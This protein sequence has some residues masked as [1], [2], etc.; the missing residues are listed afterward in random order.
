MIELTML[1]AKDGDSILLSYGAGSSPARKHRI[2]ID[3]G[4]AS[5]YP[6]FVPLLGQEPIDVLVIT[7][8]DQDHVLGVLA[9]FDDPAHPPL[10]D[11]WFNGFD[12]LV[13]DGLEHFGPRD[14]EL[15]TAALAAQ[16][17]AWNAAFGGR[18]VLAGR[19]T[20]LADGAAVS[21]LSPE[22]AQLDRLRPFWE[23][24]CAK[25]GLIPGLKPTAPQLPGFESLGA[26]AGIEELAAS[27]FVPDGS[28]TNASS[29][30]FLF[31][32]EGIRLVFT[33]DGDDGCLARSLRPLAEQEGGRLRIDALKVP[34]HGSAANL[35][36][37]M[38]GLL[39]CPT[40][41][42]STSGDRHHHPDD[43]CMARILKFGGP[44]KDVVFN[45]R[46]RAAKWQDPALEEE[47]GYRVLGPEAADGFATL[48][49][50]PP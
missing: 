7:H 38:L 9:L 24:E 45:Y 13:G 19:S 26:A 16:G 21:V 5:S 49:W 10:A 20:G 3:G 43:E 42:I 25:H 36:K 27:R 4:R 30:G 41:L 32:F 8:V 28:L 34:H 37:E 29:I 48:A 11:V 47:Y 18:T 31:E 22:R 14:G 44:A 23:K 46:S 17:L 35:S 50:G 1:P 39:D 2:L 40:Y 15:V 33:G 6:L 12:H